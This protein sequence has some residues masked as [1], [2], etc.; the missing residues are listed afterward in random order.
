M[1]LKAMTVY[2][3]RQK[4]NVV[5]FLHFFCNKKCFCGR[6]EQVREACIIV[7]VCCYII[8]YF[9]LPRIVLLYIITGR[10]EGKILGELVEM[11]ASRLPPVQQ[12]NLP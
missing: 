12:F 10:S 1:V 3:K 9:I 7:V 2:G 11:H 4:A 8:V 5:C 6:K